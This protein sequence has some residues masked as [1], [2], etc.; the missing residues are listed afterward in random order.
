MISCSQFP[1]HSRDE[2]VGQGEREEDCKQKDLA[3]DQLSGSVFPE[4]E[5]THISSDTGYHVY[6]TQDHHADL[7]LISINFRAGAKASLWQR[8]HLPPTFQRN[9][10]KVSS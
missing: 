7:D 6:H 10:R 1:I 8:L 5:C 3:Q 4:Q 2:A 9:F